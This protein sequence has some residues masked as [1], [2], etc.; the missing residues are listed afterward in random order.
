[1]DYKLQNMGRYQSVPPS[2]THS[3]PGKKWR[4]Q[5]P[6]GTWSR[7]EDSN[8]RRVN[9]TDLQSVAIGHSATPG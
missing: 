7:G 2:G 4:S 9:P 1:M 3:L 6:N 5:V 8:L